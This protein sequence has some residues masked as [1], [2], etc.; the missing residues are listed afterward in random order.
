MAGDNVPGALVITGVHTGIGR[1][2]AGS[3]LDS[4]RTVYG[5]S[6]SEPSGLAGRAGFFF[7]RADFSE[8]AAVGAIV[9]ARVRSLEGTERLQTVEIA[10]ERLRSAFPKLLEQPSG[11][12]LDLREM[13]L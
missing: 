10:V 4:G 5:L 3:F 2:L 6:R 7:A 12:F 1:A 11:S 13:S 9:S 8:P